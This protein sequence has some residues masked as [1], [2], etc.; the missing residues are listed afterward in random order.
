MGITL[1]KG[2]RECLA[3]ACCSQVC[4][5]YKEKVK[6]KYKLIVEIDKVSLVEVETAIF[7][8]LMY[9][10]RIDG[11]AYL[12]RGSYGNDLAIEWKTKGKIIQQLT[13]NFIVE[14]NY[15]N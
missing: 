14:R 5:P 12:S 15:G 11:F 9:E 4:E 7:R 1:Y 6:N 8:F 3:M 10:D 2:C 13:L